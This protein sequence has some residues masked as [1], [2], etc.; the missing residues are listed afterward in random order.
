[1]SNFARTERQRLAGLL[2]TAGPDAPTLC[3][4]WTT[5]D[6]AAHLVLRERRAD[7]APGIRVKALAGW[8]AKVQAGYAARPYEELVRVFRSGPPRLSPFALR[9]VDEA[10]NTVEYFVHAEDVRRAGAWEPQQV[11]AELADALWK[12]LPLL[13]RFEAG[14]RTPAQLV[15]RTPDGRSLTVAHKTGPTV[16]ITGEPGELVLFAFGRG[17][18]ADLQADGPAEAVAALRAALPLP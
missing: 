10:A 9:A 16:Q 15:L 2:A 8:T 7:A 4:G 14:R 6:L 3:A 5:R 12:R 17:K 13:A 1:M 18:Q 11:T